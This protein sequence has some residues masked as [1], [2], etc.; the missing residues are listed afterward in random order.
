M[1]KGAVDL[2]AKAEVEAAIVEAMAR[3]GPDGLD[4]F[5]VAKPFMARGMSKST[6]YRWIGDILASGRPGA[7]IEAKVVKAVRARAKRAPDPAKA[8][9]EEIGEVMPTL[10]TVAEV[11]GVGGV[12]EVIEKLQEC[13]KAAEQVMKHAR[14]DAG[15]PRNVRALLAGSEHLRRSLETAV[16]LREAMR[17]DRDLDAKSR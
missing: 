2:P 4:K 14:N 13:F 3:M 8:V 5:S 9:A 7:A 17:E 11:T 15:D 10:A 16:K 6:V 1:T 12:I